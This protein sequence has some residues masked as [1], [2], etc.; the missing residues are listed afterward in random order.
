MVQFANLPSKEYDEESLSMPDL[1]SSDNEA[2]NGTLKRKSE[3]HGQ[4][5]KKK[6]RKS[7]KSSKV[8]GSKSHSKRRH[9]V[10]KPARDPRD[11]ASPAESVGEDNAVA[12]SPSPVI[13]FDGLSKPSK[14]KS[15][16][17]GYLLILQRSRY[18]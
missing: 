5:T 11:E 13:D 12:R 2:A 8:N 16:F 4:V 6:R 9:S 1:S 17:G 3:V 7:D 14:H 10:S 18:S 15:C